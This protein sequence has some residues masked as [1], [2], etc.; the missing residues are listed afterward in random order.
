MSL[1]S[2]PL[3]PRMCVELQGVPDLPQEKSPPGPPGQQAGVGCCPR[4]PHL[5]LGARSPLSAR[6]PG[7]CRPPESSSVTQERRK[8][9]VIYRQREA[10]LPL[11]SAR[12]NKCPVRS[13]HLAK[14]VDP[15][16]GP[17]QGNKDD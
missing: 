8:R 3:V 2:C 11:S 7:Q 10:G 9:S 13:A 16:Q 14:D 15:G 4:Q 17:K 1:L 6:A 12:V 5:R